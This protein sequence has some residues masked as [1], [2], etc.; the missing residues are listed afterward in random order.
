VSY[1]GASSLVAVRT[2]DG[3]LLKAAAPHGAAAAPAP[4]AGTPVWLAW[5]ASAGTLLDR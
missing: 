3:R 5:P 1:F 4:A 2:A